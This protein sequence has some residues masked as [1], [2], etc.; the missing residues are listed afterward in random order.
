M[1][2]TRNQPEELPRS[3][4]SSM[5]SGTTRATTIIGLSSL[6][7]AVLQS[8]CTFFAA[9]DGL[10]VGIGIGSL[11]LS[12]STAAVIDHL[13]VDWLRVPMILLALIGSIL[14]LVVLWQI[15]RL[16]ARPEA[17]WRQTGPSASRLRMERVQFVLSVVTLLVIAI[18]ER[19]HLIWQHHL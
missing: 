6:L 19:Q 2:L 7:F 12:S 11:V 8:V 1:L 5:G 4:P 14:N 18:E 3:L 13:H 9:L 10:R 15:R 16:R 17:Q